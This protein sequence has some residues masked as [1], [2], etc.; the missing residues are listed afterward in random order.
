MKPRVLSGIQPT[1]VLH[2]GNYLGSLKNFVALQDTY[3]CIFFIADYHSLTE[4]YSPQKKSEQILDVA[5][6][7]VAAGLDP[8]KCTLFVQSDIPETTELAW[9]FS[10]ITSVP[11]LF[12]MTQYKEKSADARQTPN[13]GLLTY[14]VLQAADI[15]L[16]KAGLVPVGEDQLQH[17][18]LTREIARNYNRRFGNTFPEPKPLL[19]K[20]PR[21][22]SLTDPSKKMSKSHGSHT[23]IALDDEPKVIR[24]KL[25]KAV[26]DSGP[27]HNKDLSSDASAKEEKS[28]GVANLFLLLQEFG[29]ED[30]TAKFEKEYAKGTIR[31]TELK[32]VLAERI[33]DHFADFCTKKTELVKDKKKLRAIF[34]DGAEHAR[35]IAE[36]T[37]RE[38][39]EKMGLSF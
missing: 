22:M 3:E 36:A 19:T 10:T 31:Y 29:S 20:V 18:E 17:L 9:L 7:M 24:E 5:A 26:T 38:V 35:T 16:Y 27:V 4:S 13:T 25:A 33:A 15:L 8:K 6:S 1:G 21:L 32:A 39:R 34:Q 23:Y 11:L 37:M 28:A 14:P 2:I 30:D 12:R